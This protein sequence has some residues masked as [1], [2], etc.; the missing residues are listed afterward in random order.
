MVE[1]RPYE[2]EMVFGALWRVQ[3]AIPTDSILII[4]PYGVM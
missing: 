1:N 2:I 3:G 4:V